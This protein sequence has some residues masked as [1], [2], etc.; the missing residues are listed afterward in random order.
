MNL[1]CDHCRHEWKADI[2]EI[3]EWNPADLI[4]CPACTKLDYIIKAQRLWDKM[5]SSS[6]TS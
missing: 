3:L 1:A 6:P 2:I 4:F 5:H